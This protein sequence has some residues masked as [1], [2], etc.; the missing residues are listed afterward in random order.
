MLAEKRGNNP[1]LCVPHTQQTIADIAGLTRETANKMMSRL[2]RQGLIAVS[3]SM[4]E[5]LEPEKL[6]RIGSQ[7]K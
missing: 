2:Q 3:S 4:I 7:E 6:Y 1:F 5:L